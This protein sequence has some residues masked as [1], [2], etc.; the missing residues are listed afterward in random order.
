[1]SAF[2]I[3]ATGTGIGKT[4][5]TTALCYQ[6]RQRGEEVFA[7]KPVITGFDAKDRDNDTLLIAKS[8]GLSQ[9]EGTIERISPFRF[10]EPLSPDIA[11]AIE[12]RD[13]DPEEVLEFCDQAIAGHDITL[14]EGI[15]GTHAPLGRDF[16]VADWI[17]DLAIPAVLVTGSYLG[18]LSHTLVTVE[19][20]QAMGISLK[21][22][23]VAQSEDEPMPLEKTVTA[24]MEHLPGQR[25]FSLPR[26]RN[27]PLFENAPDLTGVLA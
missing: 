19:A 16:L 10:R 22:V 3:T 20:L 2:F 6:L 18:T 27:K 12:G 24:L 4:V 21:A 23:V 13:I 9:D 1:M 14:I 15:G 7:I 8:L 5:L 11:A 26:I 17:L 25:I